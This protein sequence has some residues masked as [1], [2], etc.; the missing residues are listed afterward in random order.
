[1]NIAFELAAE[2]AN[3]GEIPVG[4]VI[5]QDSGVIASARNQV[6]ERGNACNHAEM[7]AIAAACEKMGSKNLSGCDLYVT[8]EPCPMCA[9]AISFSRIRRVYFG[10]Y[11]PKSGGEFLF[12]HPQ[13]HH[14]PEVY[15]GIEESRA[16]EMLQKFFERLRG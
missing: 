4:A 12:S 8:L 14:K 9:S 1:M 3:C 13:L 2:A 7:L 10:A 11:D 15:G 5:V 6:E 16:R